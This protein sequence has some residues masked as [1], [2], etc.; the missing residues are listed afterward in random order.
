MQGVENKL[1][2]WWASP[3]L[4][5]TALAEMMGSQKPPRFCSGMQGGQKLTPKLPAWVQLMGH[6]AGCLVT[7][8]REAHLPEVD[9]EGHVSGRVNL[10]NTCLA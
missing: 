8:T 7:K 4:I 1:G 6:Q 5:K 10:I 2:A 3:P 9:T